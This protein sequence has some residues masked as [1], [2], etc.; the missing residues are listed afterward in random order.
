MT[1]SFKKDC[2]VKVKKN[3]PKSV[4]RLLVFSRPTVGRQYTNSYRQLTDSNLTLKKKHGSDRC[5]LNYI[6]LFELIA[7][8]DQLRIIIFSLFIFYYL[9]TYQRQ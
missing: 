6:C 5:T 3:S 9:L 4:G 8:A 7:G 2:W 1:V